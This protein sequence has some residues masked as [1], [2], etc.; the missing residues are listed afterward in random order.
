[1]R[2]NFQFILHDFF[3]VYPTETMKLTK[4][5]EK[6]NDVKSF[7]VVCKN[8]EIFIEIANVVNKFM[9]FNFPLLITLSQ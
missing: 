2:E 4:W 7:T 5:E 1:M 9:T 3:T 6:E 8:E